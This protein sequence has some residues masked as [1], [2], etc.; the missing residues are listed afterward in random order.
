MNTVLVFDLD[1]TLYPE[2]E[3][4]FSGYKA[5]DTFL[6]QNYKIESFFDVAS[7]LFLSGTRNRIFDLALSILN[8]EYDEELIQILL[9]VYRNHLP[10]I[11]LYADA[12]WALNYYKNR[13][14]LGLI[15]DGYLTT[16][17]NKVQSL[18]LNRKINYKVYSDQYG[19][20]NWKPSAVPYKQVMLKY[21]K[22]KY[23]YVGDNPKKDFV[24]AKKLGWNT[25]R[26]NRG[27]GEYDA[28]IVDQQFE[29]DVQI[30]SLYQL[31]HHLNMISTS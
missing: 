13:F 19:R 27:C 3:F 7:K 21:G 1:D 28:I 30:E 22:S 15:T 4:V 31:E 11:N 20:E 2:R 23:I 29:A 26:V 14:P 8:I 16:Q 10:T 12:K 6:K 24:T 5:V 17:R 25:I 9:R 18:G